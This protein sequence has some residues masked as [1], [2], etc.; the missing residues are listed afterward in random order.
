MNGSTNFRAS[1]TNIRLLVVDLPTIL[2]ELLQNAFESIHDIQV[3]QPINDVQHLLDPLKV[4]TADVI[5]L[6]SSQ[7]ENISS[8]VAVLDVL[9]DRHKNAKVIAVT[10]KPGY[11]EVISLFRAGVRGVI[12]NS[13]LR[14]EMLCKSIRCVHQGQIWANNEQLSY[15][16]S[17]VMRPKCADVTD[18]LGR[19]ILTTREQQVLHL[20]ADGLSNSEL[21]TVLQL[22]EHTIKN[23]L[24]RI[25]DKLGVSNRME[26]VLYAL[27]PRDAKPTLK[28][29]STTISQN[30]I[31]MIKAG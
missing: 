19:R 17:S 2:S 8:A 26:A 16:V 23:H 6:G 1:G 30:K 9:P 18:S 22:S 10:Q 29:A 28:V 7:V 4:G 25:Y 14:F 21:A 3:M 11:S 15:L 24:F 20:L 27:T 13:N 5:L 12:C 31:R